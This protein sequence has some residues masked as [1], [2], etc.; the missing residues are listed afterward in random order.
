MRQSRIP[1]GRGLPDRMVRPSVST[2]CAGMPGCLRR[3][4]NRRWSARSTKHRFR[5]YISSRRASSAW[6]SASARKD[7]GFHRESRREPTVGQVETLEI[8]DIKMG[9]KVNTSV[10]AH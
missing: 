2:E 3:P 10:L 9:F 5:A 4:T 1:H 7:S 6:N 8:F